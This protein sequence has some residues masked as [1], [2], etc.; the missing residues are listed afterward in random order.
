MGTPIGGMLNFEMRGC[1]MQFKKRNEPSNP[2]YAK[3]P[4]LLS[5]LGSHHAAHERDDS[6]SLVSGIS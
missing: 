3:A 6:A 1:W 2:Q 4:W 5:H